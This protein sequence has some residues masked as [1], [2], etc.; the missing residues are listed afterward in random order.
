[1][2]NALDRKLNFNQFRDI[3]AIAILIDPITGN[4]TDAN[5]SALD[6]YGYTR[7][8]LCSMKIHA[9]N[10]LS[11]REV[12]MEMEAAKTKQRNYFLFKHQIKNGEIRDVEVYSGPIEIKNKEYLFSIIYDITNTAIKVGDIRDRL[13]QMEV[14]VICSHCHRIRDENSWIPSQLF[15]EDKIYYK[16]HSICEYCLRKHFPEYVDDES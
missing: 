9:I 14:V 13:E 7:D 2:P 3:D 5:N 8:E 10:Q 11:K 16:S 6:F 15:L 1:M 12:E 4:I